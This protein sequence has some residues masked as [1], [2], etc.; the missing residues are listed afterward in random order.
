MELHA[1]LWEWSYRSVLAAIL[2][3]ALHWRPRYSTHMFGTLPGHCDMAT[4]SSKLENA[5]ARRKLANRKKP[6]FVTV[7]PG[8]GLGYRR[9][10][11]AGT[12]S[13]RSTDGHGT[14]WVKRIALA[15]DQEPAD[16]THVLNFWQA[17]DRARALARR[18]HLQRAARTRPPDRRAGE[19]A[20]RAARGCGAP[21]M[22]RRAH[23]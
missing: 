14:D 21:Q 9:N 8:I 12:W 1:R 7:A 18:R 17:Q 3:L 10:Q 15:D 23:G 11:G 4:R 2:S 5:T 22:A 6:Y 16:G 19:Q 20:G 13:V